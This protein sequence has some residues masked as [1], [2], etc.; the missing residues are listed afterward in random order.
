[1]DR[2][3]F[4][5]KLFTLIENKRNPPNR[6]K[7]ACQKLTD[8]EFRSKK[9]DPRLLVCLIKNFKLQRQKAQKLH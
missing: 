4:W 7:N 8:V 5:T 2:Q 3:V 1:M 6:K 9:G